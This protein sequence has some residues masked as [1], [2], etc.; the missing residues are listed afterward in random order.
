MY[1]VDNTMQNSDLNGLAYKPGICQI[2]KRCALAKDNGL[3]TAFT[4]AHEIGH[5]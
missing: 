4:I 3:E 5:T 2:D 1:V